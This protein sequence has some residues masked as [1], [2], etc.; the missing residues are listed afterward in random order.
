MTEALS[1]RHGGLFISFEGTEGS[2]KTTQ[3]RLLVDRLRGL[4]FTVTQNQEPGATTIGTQIRKILLDPAHQEM[5]PMTELFLMFASRTQAAAQIILPALK[6]GEIVVTDRFTDSTL[7][8][9]GIARGI[10][11]ETVLNVHRLALGDL[12]PDVTICTTVDVELG[13]SRAHTRNV[14]RPEEVRLDQQ[15]LEFHLRVA[16]GY[17]KIAELEPQRFRLVDGAG[18]R[19]EVAERIWNVLALRVGQPVT[20]P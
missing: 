15:S 8:Y 2:G 6:R 10:G 11:F 18:S 1:G 17:R 9:Q 16:E 13:L 5:A 19:E 3:M 14:M 4:G 20:T 7:A 12:W